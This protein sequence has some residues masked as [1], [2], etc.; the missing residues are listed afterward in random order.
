[1]SETSRSTTAS[2]RLALSPRLK[3]CEGLRLAFSTAAPASDGVA[4]WPDISIRPAAIATLD[5]TF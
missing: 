4:N 5:L 2:T 1:M 3:H